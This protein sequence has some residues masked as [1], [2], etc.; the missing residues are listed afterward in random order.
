MPHVRATVRAQ[1]AAGVREV[2]LEVL[3]GSQRPLI[4]PR[5]GL[6]DRIA[7]LTA[8]GTAPYS[9]I[10]AFTAAVAAELE[11]KGVAWDGGHPGGAMR[12]DLPVLRIT[13]TDLEI[14]DAAAAGAVAFVSASYALV[15]AK[16][17]STW[18]V[19]ENRLPIRLGGPDLT[20]SVLA[21]IAAEAVHQGLASF[22]ASTAP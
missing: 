11:A 6:I 4:A 14:Q 15:D 8:N 22:P 3:D 19:A 1:G 9:A 18:E 5:P 13:L 10:D 7:Q 21:R 16:G 17:E 20:R 2:I 12:T